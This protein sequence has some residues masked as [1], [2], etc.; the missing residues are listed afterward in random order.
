M[1]PLS[2]IWEDVTDTGFPSP[3][4]GRHT[5]HTPKLQY[6]ASRSTR[7]RRGK[8]LVP[9]RRFS[10]VLIKPRVVMQHRPPST[11][12]DHTARTIREFFRYVV[13]VV[14]FAIGLLRYPL[15]IL[16]S[17]WLLSFVTVKFIDTL[18]IPFCQLPVINN[19]LPC[20]AG[21]SGLTLWA[22]YPKLMEVQS[23]SFEQLL[24][25]SVGGSELSLE[26][27]KA[28]IVTSDLV[29]L[30]KFSD[31]KSRDTMARMLQE[32]V[33]DARLAGRS[34]QRLSSKIGGAVDR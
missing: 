15:G 32:F 26:V 21:R 18:H 25:E 28:E 24:D 33:S 29:T 19:L 5:A 11:Y 27:K 10:K 16:L 34:L 14:V 9:H 13:D 17:L 12:T 22:D 3:D 30:I 20:E 7:K 6:G 31:L 23:T 4:H 2:N 1:D 8:T